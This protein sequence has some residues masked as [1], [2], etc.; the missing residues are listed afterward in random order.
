[1]A[2]LSRLT[3]CTGYPGT[4]ETT[5]AGCPPIDLGY[6]HAFSFSGTPASTRDAPPRCL[7]LAIYTRLARWAMFVL[8]TCARLRLSPGLPWDG[9]QHAP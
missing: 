6:A 2:N 8:S 4:T 9:E 7:A 1:M 3:V 5:D